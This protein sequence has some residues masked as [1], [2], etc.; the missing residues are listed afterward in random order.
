MRKGFR[1]HVGGEM[2]ESYY[3]EK[4]LYRECV[5]DNDWKIGIFFAFQENSSDLFANWVKA[6]NNWMSKSRHETVLS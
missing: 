1:R 6:K 2:R 3:E 5:L 4:A